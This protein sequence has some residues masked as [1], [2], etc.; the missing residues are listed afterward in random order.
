VHHRLLRRFSRIDYPTIVTNLCLMVAIVL[1]PS[2]TESVGDVDTERLPLPVA[3]MAVDIVAASVLS[4]LVF[5][6]AVRRRLLADQPDRGEVIS[7]TLGG[8]VPALVFAVSIPVAYL[9]SPR[10]GTLT[11]LSL[12]VLAPIVHRLVRVR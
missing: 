2:C 9:V 3:V 10:A 7:Y 12:L 4:T 6:I 11:W 8:L 1:L 5:L